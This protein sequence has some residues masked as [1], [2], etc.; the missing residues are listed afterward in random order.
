MC[1]SQL[2]DLATYCG[3][4]GGGS[5]EAAYLLAEKL[6]SVHTNVFFL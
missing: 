6:G 5:Y 4:G 3:M 1:Y 2:R